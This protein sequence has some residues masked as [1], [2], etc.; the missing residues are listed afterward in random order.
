M[1]YFDGLQP[2]GLFLLLDP[3]DLSIQA[4]SGNCFEWLGQSASALLG[5]TLGEFFAAPQVQILH[6]AVQGAQPLLQINPLTLVYQ[7]PAMCAKFLAIVHHNGQGLVLELEIWRQ[8]PSA[9]QVLQQTMHL[10]QRLARALDASE[11][12]SICVNEWLK[13]QAFEHIAI[14][15]LHAADEAELLYEKARPGT[16]ALPINLTTPDL[17]QVRH[18]FQQVALHWVNHL[19]YQPVPLC[20]PASTEIVAEQLDLSGAQL[21]GLPPELRTHWQQS[22]QASVLSLALYKDRLLWGLVLASSAKAL[23]LS[24]A[25]RLLLQQQAQLLSVQLAHLQDLQG[26]L[27]DRQQA[28]LHNESETRFQS[29]FTHNPAAML[30]VDP[31]S[32]NIL[33]AN[34][35]AEKL[36]GY[37][38]AQ[39]QTMRYVDLQATHWQAAAQAVL[40][41]DHPTKQPVE[42][43][44]QHAQGYSIPAALSTLALKLGGQ[45]V[46]CVTY[47]DLTER[48]QLEASLK[49]GKGKQSKGKNLLRA[50]Q[51][52][53]LQLENAQRIARIG[54]WEYE[55]P[56]GISH[57]S[58]E[59]FELLDVPR[60]TA[61]QQ[62]FMRFFQ[63]VHAN[64]R[65][66][67]LN[68]FNNAT[69]GGAPGYRCEFRIV[70]RSGEI[71]HLHA[72]GE[73]FHDLQGQPKTFISTVQ[74][75]SHLYEM[76]QLRQHML[77]I[78]ENATDLIMSFD[79]AGNTVYLNQAGR[80]MLGFGAEKEVSRL[81]LEAYHDSLVAQQMREHI[82][83][84]VLQKGFWQGETLFLTRDGR[85]IPCSQVL[86]TTLS[87]DGTPAFISSI[88]RDIAESQKIQNK[89]RNS[90]ERLNLSQQIGHVGSWEWD[91]RS[92][93]LYWSDEIFRIFGLHPQQFVPT[94]PA[95]LKRIH[96]E[97]RSIVEVAVKTAIDN[98]TPYC[99]EHRV[100]HPNGVERLVLEQG[101]VHYDAQGAPLRMLGLVQDITERK[102]FELDL[103]QAKEAAESASQAKSVFL[104]S[105]SHELR[106]PLNAILGYAQLL[107]RDSSL[108]PQ[109]RDN[110]HVIYNSG[111]YLLELINE[112]LDLSKIEAG[113]M[114][115]LPEPCHLGHLLQDICALFSL[116]CQEKGIAFKFTAR[117]ALPDFLLAD[118]KRLRQILINLLGNAV[119]FTETGYVHLKLHYR[120]DAAAD[121]LLVLV[122]D[123]GVGMN[124]TELK[125]I[126]KPFSQAGSNRY[127]AQGTGLGLAIT[128]KLVNLMHGDLHVLSTPQQGSV[129]W[130]ELHLARLQ[131]PQPLVTASNATQRINGYQRTDGQSQA[132][133]ILIVDDILE[134]R[135]LLVQLLESIGFVCRV[136]QNGQLALEIAACWQADAILM[137]LVM[138][139]LDGLEATRCLRQM[140]NYTQTPI[141]A[142]SASAFASHRQDS[143]DAGCQAHIDKP[144][145]E[146]LLFSLLRQHLPLQWLFVQDEHKAQAAQNAT[147][148]TDAVPLPPAALSRLNEFAQSGKIIEIQEYAEELANS[149][150]AY[151]G[152]ARQL[153]QYADH[154]DM[155]AV[156][157]LLKRQTEAQS[158]PL[159]LKI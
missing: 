24:Y 52:H 134:N 125:Q 25:Q 29:L 103:Q 116:R 147:A 123:T 36:L 21:L 32:G 115:L 159:E 110:L 48:R 26:W 87:S 72:V 133:Q 23:E 119:K 77:D 136:A 3:S 51:H 1:L 63:R 130:A 71:R 18:F 6:K 131:H 44:L 14:Y 35:T 114:E 59:M 98:Q 47:Q 74:D 65:V 102:R 109:Q 70:R 81:G 146:D 37:A 16:P 41:A 82:F 66:H 124:E 33:R 150:E 69:Q 88:A 9:S 5:K 137:D 112:I 62:L 55:L 15:T 126:F 43:E 7:S 22:A 67:V 27:I 129:F 38:Q 20:T 141:I 68:A 101:E 132:L 42:I 31:D 56:E 149:G 83:P 105:M 113:H 107:K 128:R 108:N 84:E 138:P 106:T 93:D 80:K 156:R 46:L 8:E 127:K 153:H 97:D 90:E 17:P 157:S 142:V 40:V 19:D 135:Q 54:S 45:S 76:Q 11:L 39:L 139:V 58:E 121:I 117:S 79:R 86:F 78:L 152:V 73:V 122:E 111:S 158:A 34:Q 60:N 140:P 12:L 89:L 92:N 148:E 64:E 120:S 75:V 104:A 2:R 30:L 118:E 154:L 95:F 144:F 57:W 155:K 13:T 100:V 145:S 49:V 99:I 96:P 91:I 143:L 94:Y 151:A 10:S 50:L 85:S 61:T 28:A 53:Q 4:V